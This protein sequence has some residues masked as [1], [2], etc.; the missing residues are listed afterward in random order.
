MAMFFIGILC[1]LAMIPS[2]S[3]LSPGGSEARSSRVDHRPLKL[4]LLVLGVTALIGM[5]RI[6]PAVE[7]IQS[8][9]GMRQALSSNPKV[10]DPAFIR[11]YSFEQLWKET[12]GFD[13]RTGLVTTGSIPVLLSGIAFVAF[14]RSTLAWGLSLLLFGWLS[15]AHHARIDLLE[16]LW[17]L[18]VFEAISMPDKYFS[19]Q[20]AFTL[21]IVAGRSFSPLRQL[22][23]RSVEGLIATILIALS[24]GFLY[25]KA[26][27]IQRRTF[28]RD[29][30]RVEARPEEGFFH[31]EGMSLPRARTY[32]PHSLAY[33][34]VRR[35]VGTLDW[36]TG[37]PMARHAVPKYFVDAQNTYTRNPVYRGEAFFEGS[38]GEVSFT[39]PPVMRPNSIAVSVDVKAPSVLVINQNFHRDWHADHGKLLDRDGRLAL[40]LEDT[41]TYTIYLRYYPRSFYAGLAVT[42]SS[43]LALVWVCWTYTTGRLDRWSQRGPLVLKRWSQAV[44]WSIK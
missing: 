12:V 5:M 17:H 27:D 23:S 43:L 40:Q 15:M 11:A 18:P 37:V 20:I 24:V 26:E 38:S 8:Q 2:T 21:A 22:R 35:N 39:K 31:I 14:W 34:N 7:L 25:P 36:Y 16:L 44:L 4:F 9:G 42:T 19:F 1:V 30:P 41:G 28:T 10:Y 3:A 29:A 33:F 13:G 6:L 32:P